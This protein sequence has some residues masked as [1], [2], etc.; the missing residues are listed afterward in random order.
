M[1]GWHKKLAGYSHRV[2]YDFRLSSVVDVADAE[3]QKK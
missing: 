3:L 2:A 1:R